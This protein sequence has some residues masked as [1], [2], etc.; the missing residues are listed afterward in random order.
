MRRDTHAWNRCA[1]N[2]T[3][4]GCQPR[5]QVASQSLVCHGRPRNPDKSGTFKQVYDPV[6][7]QDPFNKLLL[8]AGRL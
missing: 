3:G 4:A 2:Y 8:V 5:L 6:R 7:V 1:R